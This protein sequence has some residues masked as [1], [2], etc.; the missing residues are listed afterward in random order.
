MARMTAKNRARIAGI[1]ARARQARI[2]QAKKTRTPE[3]PT[4]ILRQ[5]AD[6]HLPPNV[7]VWNV[8]LDAL[9]RDAT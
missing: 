8:C 2:L 7:W 4:K 6:L 9:M 5:L 3:I 1:K